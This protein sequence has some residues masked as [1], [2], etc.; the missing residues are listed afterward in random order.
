MAILLLNYSRSGGTLLSSVLAR[1]DNVVLVS[2]VNPV[3]NAYTSV[4]E[5]V[6]EWYGIDISDGSFTEMIKELNDFCTRNNKTL[7][8]R[9]Y[10]F[11]DFTPNSINDFQPKSNFSALVELQNHIP[12]QVI[13][14]VRDAYDVW[15]SRNCPPK[16]SEGYLKY[17]EQLMELKIPIFKYEDF[18]ENPEIEL[19]KIC[20]SVNIRYDKKHLENPSKYQNITGDNQME[21]SSRGRKLNQISRLKRKQIPKKWSVKAGS[22]IQLKEANKMLSYGTDFDDVEIDKKDLDW[23]NSLKW[24]LNRYRN[25]SLFHEF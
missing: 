6:K 3:S 24:M 22:D 15:I 10:S 13:S 19:S 8:I 12:L 9:D 23:V 17:V 18:C 2:E 25:P 7:I 14:F 11:V 20:D 21:E 16:F 1:L 5:Q 4:K